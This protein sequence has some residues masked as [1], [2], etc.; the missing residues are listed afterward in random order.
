MRSALSKWR[1]M[2]CLTTSALSL[3]ARL[4]RSRAIWYSVKAAVTTPATI[5]ARTDHQSILKRRSLARPTSTRGRSRSGALS[6]AILGPTPV[7]LDLTHR[8]PVRAAPR[9]LLWDEAL[10]S[11][12]IVTTAE[13]P[14]KASETTFHHLDATVHVEPRKVLRRSRSGARS[15]RRPPKS[16]SL[17]VAKGVYLPDAP[18]KGSLC[19]D[20]SETQR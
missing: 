8:S 1:L 9:L 16:G 17:S 12:C 15:V 18:R 6:L 13:R 14:G 2:C 20:Q 19:H 4:A 11:D 3:T 7:P 5:I 10:P